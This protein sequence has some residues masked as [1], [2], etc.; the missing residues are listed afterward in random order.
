M[1]QVDSWLVEE[2][3]I[4]K[5]TDK[6][7]FVGSETGLPRYL[8]YPWFR[9]KGFGS[10]VQLRYKGELYNAEIYEKINPI[11]NQPILRIK[12]K[13]LIEELILDTNFLLT[14]RLLESVKNF[15]ILDYPLVKFI[16]DD[17]ILV[18]ETC[19]SQKLY[20]NALR[21]GA[22]CVDDYINTF[23]YN[24]VIKNIRLIDK[25]N[26]LLVNI[27]KSRINVYTDQL[28]TGY[29]GECSVFEYEKQ[30]LSEVENLYNDCLVTHASLNNEGLGYDIISYDKYGNIKYIEV[31]T[32][33][34]KRD[35]PFF[36]SKNELEF[37]NNHPSSYYLYRLFDFVPNQQKINFYVLK[38][39]LSKTINLTPISFSASEKE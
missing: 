15:K 32:T 18:I 1:K 20:N 3:Y 38:G 19:A 35:T 6:S 30:K 4:I 13:I 26:E 2:N 25:N 5:I 14:Y 7:F 39:S 29:L 22:Y 36:V 37:S 8:V 33:K 17:G 11:L 28:E 12:D 16:F 31:K 9:I 23:V 27:F 21:K 24:Q 34:D 10:N